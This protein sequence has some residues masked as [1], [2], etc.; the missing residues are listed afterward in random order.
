MILGEKYA[1]LTDLLPLYVSISVLALFQGVIYR[2]CA[3]K[4][5]VRY[6][7]VYT[8][9]TIIAQVTML[10]FFGL[11]DIWSILYFNGALVLTSLLINLVLFTFEYT[12]YRNN[13]FT[14]D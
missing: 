10:F 4:G 8:P 3:A 9:I 6:Y 5:W 14:Q 13:Y 2:F 7:F 12:R 1:N 11:S